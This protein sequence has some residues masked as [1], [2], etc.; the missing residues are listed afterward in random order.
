MLAAMT[1]AP[2]RGFLVGFSVTRL[3]LSTV[4]PSKLL[5]TS[6]K[7]LQHLIVTTAVRYDAAPSAPC[8]TKFEVSI[9]TSSKDITGG[10]K[11]KK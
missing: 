8:C 2:L 10:P 3:M 7:R 4:R 6:S 5:M 11:L 9:F 1:A